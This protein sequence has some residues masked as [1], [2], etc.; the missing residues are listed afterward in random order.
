[1]TD[2]TQNA[3]PVTVGA[4]TTQYVLSVDSVRSEFYQVSMA[5]WLDWRAHSRALASTAL[6]MDR[7]YTVSAGGETMRVAGQLVAGP[8]PDVLGFPFVTGRGF[9]VEEVESGSPVAVVSESL[10][11]RLWPGEDPLGQRFTIAFA[12][13]TVV[14]VA[15]DVRVRGLERPSEPQVYLP[16][17]QVPDGSIISYTPKD[18]AVRTAS[19]AGEVWT[20]EPHIEQRRDT[21]IGMAAFDATALPGAPL[22]MAYDIA[23]TSQGDDH[24]RLLVSTADDAGSA[25]IVSI[26][27]GSNAFAWRISGIVFGSV[28]VGLIYLLAATMFGRRRIGGSAEDNRRL[29]NGSAVF[30]TNHASRQQTYN[31]S[32]NHQSLIHGVLTLHNQNLCLSLQ[33]PARALPVRASAPRPRTSP[34]HRSPPG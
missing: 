29:D 15:G 21:T 5:N 16:Y 9:T 4:T 6:L 30:R 2:T 25:E 23:S 13:R 1:M 18:L 24:G 20:I 7:S 14:G 10:A 33:L 31:Y 32:D 3:G 28:L 26:D 19:G 17:Q 11:K 12:E 27:A 34:P 22:A 8:L